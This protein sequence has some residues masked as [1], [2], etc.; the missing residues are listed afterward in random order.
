MSR[1]VA[2][3]VAALPLLFAPA[4]AVAGGWDW[5]ENIRLRPAI[6]PLGQSAAPAGAP[7]LPAA[8]DPWCTTG[9]D[10]GTAAPAT[11][12]LRSA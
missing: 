8:T 4:L 1:P 10:A 2:V 6:R 5:E 11:P 3:A 9:D 12:C 7:A